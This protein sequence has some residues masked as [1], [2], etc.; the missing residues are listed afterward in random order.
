MSMRT[1]LGETLGLGSAKSG[2]G[3]FLMQRLTAIANLPLVVFLA[4]FIV[5][6]LG[7]SRADAVAGIANPF[8]SLPLILAFVSIPWHM[9]LGMQTVI[10]DY[11][12]GTAA[13]YAALLFNSFF[14]A[15]IAVA[16]ILAILKMSFAS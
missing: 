16:G 13:K 5:A 15:A 12:H 9:R 8:V 10:E 14:T 4:W 2:T 1:P 3:H 11:V 6:H 7:A